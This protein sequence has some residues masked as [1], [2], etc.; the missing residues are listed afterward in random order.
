MIFWAAV[1]TAGYLMVRAE[2]SKQSSSFQGLAGNVSKWLAHRHKRM[3]VVSDV[4]L[5]VALD[6]PIFM[7]T[8]GDEFR[9]VGVLVNID[10]SYVRN[11]M[12]AKHFEAVIY[13]DALQDFPNGY[14][15]EFHTTPMSLDWVVKT[16][17]PPERQKEIAGFIATEWQSQQKEIMGQLKPVIQNGVRTAMKAVEDELPDILR[18]HRSEFRDLGDRYE[19]QILKEDIIPLV[20]AEILPIVEEEAVPVAEEVGQAL[21]KRVSLWSFAW[22]YIFDKSPL[23]KKNRVKAEFQ[24]FVDEEALP[25]LRSRSDEFIRL[26]ENIVKRSMENPRV[27]TVLKQNLKRVAED[28]ELHRIVWTVVKEAVIENETLRKSL[29]AYMKDRQTK[30]AMKL[31]GERLEPM[32]RDIGDMIFGTREKGITPEFSRILRSQI[33]KKDRRWFVIVSAS[34]ETTGTEVR[35]VVAANPMIYPMGFGG[36]DQSPLTPEADSR[37]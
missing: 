28:P 5:P 26:T 32:V 17:I 11:P 3:H 1:L 22:R 21:W 29:E 18:A 9:Q 16:M 36:T 4:S 24:R 7:R 35:A 34:G 13:D 19:T 33:L 37:K 20:K 31:A 15:L 2:L 25:E 8:T 30:V 14:R 6:D 12:Y 27:K 10:G 23:P